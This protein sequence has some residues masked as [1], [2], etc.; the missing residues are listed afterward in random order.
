M[1]TESRLYRKLNPTASLFRFNTSGGLL[2]GDESIQS[3]AI[4][5]GQDSPG[6]GVH[7][8]TLEVAV[9]GLYTTIRNGESCELALTGYGSELI[10][11]LIGADASIIQP[12]FTGRIGQQE[13][14]DRGRSQTTTYLGSSLSA[15]YPALSTKH[16]ATKGEAVTDVIKRLMTPVAVPSPTPVNM[17]TPGTY[18]TVWTVPTEPGTYSDLI[19]Q[20]TEDLGIL[21]RETRSGTPQILNHKQRHDSAIAGLANS[22]PL[23]RSQAISP[24]T[25]KQSNDTRPRNYRLIYTG[26]GGGQVSAIYGDPAD[27]AAEVVD[28]DMTHIQFLDPVQAEREAFARRARDWVSSYSI[29]SI[30]IDLLYLISSPFEY[31]RLQAAKLLQMQV[32]DPLYFSNDWINQLRG[33]QYSTGITESISPDSWTFEISLAP[34][35]V[36][37]GE[38]SPDIPA[39]AWESATYPWADETRSWDNT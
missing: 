25:W 30:T 22:I 16:T 29:P 8:S 10:A 14:E 4:N 18:G 20:Y 26:S 28:L 27:T 11:G 36:V 17:A 24:A 12:R 2:L 35:H 39:R 15:Q 19:T 9:N 34:S 21:V 1:S 38:I 13:I 6:G 32:G 37:T 33:I 5:R 31:H 3:I 7:P 23:T